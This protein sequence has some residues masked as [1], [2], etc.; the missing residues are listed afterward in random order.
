[1]VG[2]EKAT[3]TKGSSRLSEAGRNA[4]YVRLRSEDLQA[5]IVRSIKKEERLLP[6]GGENQGATAGQL[7]RKKWGTVRSKLVQ[8]RRLTDAKEGILL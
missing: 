2:R 4:C 1:M 6:K 3:N 7:A 5:K 8:Q